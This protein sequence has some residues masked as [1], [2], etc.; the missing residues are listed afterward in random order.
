MHWNSILTGVLSSAIASFVFLIAAW[1]QAARIRAAK[2]REFVGKYQL[3]N[4]ETNAPYGGTV[5][6]AY[7]PG[8]YRFSTDTATML[9]LFAEHRV[10]D[11]DWTGVVEVLGYSGMATGF[12]HYGKRLR[13]GGT[14]RLMLSKNCEE[15]TEQ[16]T[17]HKG[18][19][20]TNVM[21]RIS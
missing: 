10:G 20:F 1:I 13:D 3:L 2:A 15:I 16:G 19:S 7:E 5:Q 9:D 21:R 14:F 12:Y 17:P 6:I 11:E 4:A 8:R 18:P